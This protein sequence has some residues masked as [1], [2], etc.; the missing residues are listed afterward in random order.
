MATKMKKSVRQ[1]AVPRP[2]NWRLIVED[3]EINRRTIYEMF[4]KYPIYANIC[5]LEMTLNR[6]RNDIQHNKIVDCLK[7]FE[8]LYG[9]TIENYLFAFIL[10]GNCGSSFG[11]GP[12][13]LIWYPSS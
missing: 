4:L 3:W 6:W 12:F 10:R 1:K 11:I 7:E 8:P 9:E 5:T 13:E 2:E